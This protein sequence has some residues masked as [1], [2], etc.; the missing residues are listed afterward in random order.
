[1]LCERKNI[2]ASIKVC[3]NSLVGNCKCLYVTNCWHKGRIY[4]GV[5]TRFTL[6]S[7][8]AHVLAVGLQQPVH[9]LWCCC[10]HAFGCQAS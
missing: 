1:M 8:E 7:C 3:L 5:L 2:A 9:P 4:C 10:Q 6:P